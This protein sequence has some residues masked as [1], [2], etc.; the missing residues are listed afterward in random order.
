MDQKPTEQVLR[1]AEGEQRLEHET[2]RA[3][4]DCLVMKAKVRQS[5]VELDQEQY[6]NEEEVEKDHK[7]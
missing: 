5:A 7:T 1:S 2:G 4:L 3:N 6:R